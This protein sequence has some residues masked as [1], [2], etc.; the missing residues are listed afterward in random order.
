MPHSQNVPRVHSPEEFPNARP[1]SIVVSHAVPR[2][3]VDDIE[4]LGL[5]E[6][7]IMTVDLHS[8]GATMP[9]HSHRMD[10]NSDGTL[11]LVGSELLAPVAI[12]PPIGGAATTVPQ[13]GALA[14][15]PM[16]PRLIDGSRIAGL[17]RQY[18]QFRLRKITYEYVQ[19][20]NLTQSGQLCM[21]YINDP[22]DRIA[23]ETGFAALR[24]AYARS[25]SKIFSVRENARAV[26]GHPLLK[27]Y[28]T[29]SESSA[30][31]DV[32]GFLLISNMIDL[33]NSNTDA[34]PLGTVIMHY[35]IDVRAP[36]VADLTQ[37][38][39]Q[40]ASASLSMTS[41]T[42]TANSTVQVSTVSSS[43]PTNLLSTNAIYWATIV[44]CD[45]SGPGSSTWRTWK[46]GPFDNNSHTLTNGNVLFWRVSTA[47]QIY[48][49]PSFAQASDADLSGAGLAQ[50]WVAS[51]T[52]AGTK[53]FK[54][55]AINGCTLVD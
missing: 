15:I 17:L 28:Y 1:S 3:P 50:A 39:F 36:S 49:F 45:D 32:P 18:D 29:A 14:L 52:V 37:P 12:P 5:G 47:G 40:T 41:A 7:D 34:I 24:D 2:P 19:G 44:A 30:Q 33:T 31:F 13:G 55:W 10:M 43:L 53:G 25:G 26:M 48:F 27:W 20:T 46:T 35:E 21:A 38:A 8:G 9:N 16:N 54:L 6:R 23:L 22:S 51:S 42:I 11:T 4:S